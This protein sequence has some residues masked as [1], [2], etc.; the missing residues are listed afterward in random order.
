MDLFVVPTISFRLVCGLLILRHDRRSFCGSAPL[1]IQLP[2]G[3]LVNSPRPVAGRIRHATF[4]ATGTASMAPCSPGAFARWAF[5][6]DRPRHAHR[7]KTDVPN[8]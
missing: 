6:I 8:G 4:F 7:G 1:R 5:E 3:L 2:S